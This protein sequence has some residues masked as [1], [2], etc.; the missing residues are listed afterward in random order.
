MAREKTNLTLL[1][2][3]K[4][5]AMDYAKENDTSLS[6]LVED[7]LA[8]LLKKSKKATGRPTTP[9]RWEMAA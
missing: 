4:K 1:K 5:A 3:I 9:G 7:F 8:D 6:E 2:P